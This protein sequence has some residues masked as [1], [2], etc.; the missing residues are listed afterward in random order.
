MSNMSSNS[1]AGYTSAM[2]NY[3]RLNSQYEDLA[4]QYTGNEGYK[5]SLKQ[6]ALG[7]GQLASGMGAAI[8]NNARNAGLNKAQAA[9]MGANSMNSA[10]AN[11]FNNQQNQAA[12]Q[13]QSALNAT[14]QVAG[15]NLQGANMESQEKQNRFNRA[16]GNV[17]N[18][19]SMAGAA[20]Q[21]VPN[22]IPGWNMASQAVND[23]GC[24]ER[25]KDAEEAPKNISKCLE[26]IDAFLFKY[27]D[28]A[29]E[30]KP[31]LTDDKTHLG[32]MAQ[33]METNPVLENA[34]EETEDGTKAVDVKTLT[35]DNT[36][37]LS[38]L[39]KRFNAMEER[40]NELFPLGKENK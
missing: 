16:W 20:I 17:G 25:L 15:N 11:Q 30:E 24:D 36:A 37:L 38:D 26:D 18:G 8:Q 2:D 31:E 28:S 27:K 35:M 7:A 19:L 4:K 34:V 22:M 12:T 21:S 32:V 13:G 23:I 3:N 9:A 10:Y 14:N 6:A 29:Q 1:S 5:N 33:K 39:A 40:L